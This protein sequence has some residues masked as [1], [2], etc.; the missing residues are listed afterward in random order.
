M[1]RGYRAKSKWCSPFTQYLRILLN[2]YKLYGYICIL[3]YI[4]SNTKH[5]LSVVSEKK[6]ARKFSFVYLR[7]DSFALR[8]NR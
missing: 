7:F 8:Q 4:Y 2:Y 1:L 5:N 3:L 6:N